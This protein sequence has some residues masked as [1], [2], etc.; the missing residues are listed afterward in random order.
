MRNIFDQYSQPENKLTHALVSC[1]NEDDHLLNDFMKVFVGLES[2]QKNKLIVTEQGLP[3]GDSYAEFESEARG[4]PDALIYPTDGDWIVVIENK[5]SSDLTLDQLN[6]HYKTIKRY[7]FNKI[8]GLT[9]TTKK[10][11]LEDPNWNH[12]YWTDIYSLVQKHKSKSKWAHYLVEY[13]EVLEMQLTDDQ[14][15][16]E[17][18]LTTFTGVPFSYSHTYNYPEA[19]RVL[20]LLMS[21]LKQHTELEQEL[22]LNLQHSGRDAITSGRS[23]WDY[24][25]VKSIDLNSRF[26]QLIHF[27]VSIGEERM[28]CGMVL[29]DKLSSIVRKKIKNFGYDYFKELIKTIAKNADKDFNNLDGCI[30]FLQLVQR[31]WYKSIKAP[32]IDDA[33]LEFDLRTAYDDL[34]GSDNQAIKTQEEWLKACYSAFCDKESNIQISLG[35]KFLYDRCST[36]NTSEAENLCV[37]AWLACKD[38]SSK[39]LEHGKE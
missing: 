12:F 39:I 30:P 13:M 37:K 1:L 7:S 9:I 4:L 8:Y 11:D 23:V 22:N 33:K 21:N 29:P 38:F 24:I 32:S 20:K 28:Y 36:I 14:Y 3:D 5:I 6:R 15:L 31:R 35:V 18:T 16:K 10:Y 19:K 17:G 27:S 25:P 26:N 34:H 2:T